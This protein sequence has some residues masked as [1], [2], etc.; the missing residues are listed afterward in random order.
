MSQSTY[1]LQKPSALVATTR[2]ALLAVIVLVAH[3]GCSKP[4]PAPAPLASEASSTGA[5]LQRPSRPIVLA[6]VKGDPHDLVLAGGALFVTV[7]DWN[8]EDLPTEV[9]R[10]P[11]DGGEAK[12]VASGQRNGQSIIA[13]GNAVFWL[14]GGDVGKNIPDMVMKLPL[15]GGTPTKFAKTF[16][17]AD[18]GLAADTTHVYFQQ[19]VGPGHGNAS[20]L[21]RVPIAGGNPEQ[22]ATFPEFDGNVIA[23]DAN[24][25]YF[26]MLGDIMKASLSGG[27]APATQVVKVGLGRVWGLASDGR[28]LYFSD[29]GENWRS[30]DGR[31]GAVRR[32]PVDGGPVETVASGLRGRPWG[33][34][35]DAT[36]VYWV[37]N[38]ERNAG[39]MRAPKGGGSSS[40]V[41]EGQTSPTRIVMDDK[42]V[43]WANSGGDRAIAKALKEPAR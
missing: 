2:K 8:K 27:G 15:E 20:R 17:P 33:I 35:L 16:L 28:Y 21:V 30:D 23:V 10:V 37:I 14:A 13:G 39:I 32:V 1:T 42:Y 5:A 43:Y 4:E 26:T 3:A 19:L 31:T 6:R 11:L 9:L 12:V 36:H 29:R 38:A 34:A 24:N 7:Q 25:A 40:V 22:V 41:V 18:A